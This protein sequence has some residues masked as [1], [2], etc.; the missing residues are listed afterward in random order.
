MSRSILSSPFKRALLQP[1]TQVSHLPPTFL[2]PLHAHL[3]TTTTTTD[4]SPP[5][6]AFNTLPTKTPPTTTLPSPR[7]PP[8]PPKPH[9]LTRR[10]PL[11]PP[12]N[13]N[14]DLLPLLAA[15][16]PHYITA[17]LH[18]RPYLL[19][20]GD[21]LRLPFHLPHAPPGTTLRLNRASTIGSRDY[22]FRGAPWIDEELFVLRA[23]VVGVEAEP[24]RFVTKTKRRQRKVKTVKSK[25][26]FTVLRVCEL[27]VLPRGKGEEEVERVEEAVALGS[28]R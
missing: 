11:P 7:P 17:H 4:P 1:P 22:T 24:M 25:M 27:R 10:S 23:R 2:L 28:D 5:E 8:S 20:A 26:R 16:P 6:S 18:A 3:T 12:T 19:T 13:P 9:R 15:Q 14:L 21:T